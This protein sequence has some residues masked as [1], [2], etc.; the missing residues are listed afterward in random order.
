MKKL[1][2]LLL[3]LAACTSPGGQL[4]N[5]R[6]ITDA[7]CAGVTVPPTGGGQAAILPW[8]MVGSIEI[9]ATSCTIKITD[10]VKGAAPLAPASIPLP[11]PA[12]P[13]S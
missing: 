13:A 3:P 11:A 1:L 5:I 4:Q 10:W 9:T 8:G 7:G 12:V 2:L 6:G